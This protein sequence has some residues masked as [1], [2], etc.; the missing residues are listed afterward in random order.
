MKRYRNLIVFVT[1]CFALILGLV[2]C[3]GGASSSDDLQAQRARDAKAL[4]DLYSGV[5]GTW[6]GTVV[7]SA[8]GLASFEAELKMYIHYVQDG[9]APDGTPTLRPALTASF[10]PKDF[11]SETDM[12]ILV[13]TYDRNGRL[14]LTAQTTGSDATKNFLSVRGSIVRGQMDVQVSREGGVWGGFS[15]VRTSTISM[16]PTAG[17]LTEYRDRFVRING[18]VEGRYYGRMQSTDGN[19]YD[20]EVALVIVE[21]PMEGGGSRPVISAQYRRS[22]MTNIEWLLTADY[23]KQTGEILM[24]EVSSTGPGIPGALILS[25]AG[26]LQPVAG[27]YQL[28]VTVRNR[29]AVLGKLKAIRRSSGS[30]PSLP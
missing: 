14:V 25:L 22:D 2:A 28:D 17:E 21:R 12:M 8:S 10:Q 20:V 6:T 18:P 24:R 13:G 1:A 29:S 19:D 15:A 5:Q 11:I 23:N 3:S 16:A 9:T 26:T 30:T 27:T 7:N 4:E